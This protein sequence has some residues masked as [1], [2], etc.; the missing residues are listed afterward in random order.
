MAVTKSVEVK[1]HSIIDNLENGAP[2]GE[3]EIS[4]FTV[5]GTLSVQE[6]S[7]RL[8]YAEEGEGYRTLCE[9]TVRERGVSLS[10]RE[11]VVC[12][13]LFA[14][15]EECH[16]VYSVPPYKFDMSVFTRRI[17]ASLTEEGGTLQLIYGMNVGGQDKNVNMKIT[18]RVK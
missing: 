4:I 14:E 18:V 6:D 7:L 9:L 12:D 16:T 8:N 11:A 17:R 2:D 3:P 15:G 13:I 1:I 10:R 5:D